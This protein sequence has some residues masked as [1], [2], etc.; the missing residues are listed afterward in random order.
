MELALVLTI[1][2]FVWD[3]YL[4]LTSR[5]S[6]PRDQWFSDKEAT[7]RGS[8]YWLLGFSALIAWTATLLS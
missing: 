3:V 6:L 2:L 1:T 8:I 4:R 5:R 7:I